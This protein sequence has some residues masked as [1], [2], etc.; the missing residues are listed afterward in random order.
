MSAYYKYLNS[1]LSE[2]KTAF[3]DVGPITWI[4]QFTA[5]NYQQK[6]DNLLE[7]INN[8][9]FNGTKPYYKSISQGCNICGQG[10]WSCL[11]I[12]GKCNANCFYC[13]TPQLTDETPTSQQLTFDTPLAYAEYIN[14]FGFKGVA[15][16]GGEPLLFFDRTLNYI[17]TL[18]QNCNP[19]IYIWLY[20]NGILANPD[21]INKLAAAG[22]NEIRFDIG[23]T[24]YNIDKL[25]FA[26]GKIKNIT[27]E[28]P[29]IPEHAQK[30]KQLLPKLIDAGVTNLNLHQLRLTKHNAP[31]LLAR[32]YH[33]IA[34]ERPIVFESELAALDIINFAM[35]NKLDIG[36]NYCSFYFKHRHQ[37][38][39][40]RKT[41][42]TTLNKQN[43][44][45]TNNG[46]LRQVNNNN[47]SYYNYQVFDNIT[48]QKNMEL[49]KLDHKNYYIY[50]ACA[51]QNLQLPDTKNSKLLF[52][53][54]NCNIPNNTELFEIWQHEQIEHNLRDY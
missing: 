28:I 26:T 18:R 53:Q 25:K 3:A 29:A 34:A 11:F 2:T 12:T 13:P 7:S 21:N 19:D 42:N 32:Q 4:N 48:M 14:Y 31:K 50:K 36:I 47:L 17:N 22:L 52:E 39:G 1:V 5:G 54:N 40:F 16:S 38:A 20:T 45:V 44:P 9:L 41:I 24:N 10:L 23:A 49:L 43:L 30:I 51:V 46:Y 8:S 35:Q 15:F 37:K 27:V 33:Y 6:R